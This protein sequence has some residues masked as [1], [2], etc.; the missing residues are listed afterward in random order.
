[1]RAHAD[2]DIRA[3]ATSVA[4][5]LTE[6]RAAAGGGSASSSSN[7]PIQRE[8]ILADFLS[9]FESCA[10]RTPDQVLAS[11]RA[12]DMLVGSSIIVMP[13]KREDVASYYTARAIDYSKDGYLIVE[14]EDGQREE[15][16]AEE[17]SIRPNK[18][19]T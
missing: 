4:Q 19:Q 14:R 3:S 8:S 16:L 17:V 13:K 2:A 10:A 12:Y 7:T 1:M 6:Y 15:L 5:S 18:Q 9:N 11:Y